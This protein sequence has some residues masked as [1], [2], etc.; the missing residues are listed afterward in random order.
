MRMNRRASP[1]VSPFFLFFSSPFPRDCRSRPTAFC[2][3]SF[4]FFFFFFLSLSL[5]GERPILRA[6]RALPP[7]FFSFFF[8]GGGQTDQD[9]RPSRF[10]VFFLFFSFLFSFLAANL[11]CGSSGVHSGSPLPF[12]FLF[13]GDQRS[14]SW[15]CIR[16]KPLSF[17]FFFFFRPRQRIGFI[18]PVSSLPLSPLFSFLPLSF[19]FPVIDEREGNGAG[20]MRSPVTH[21][22]PFFLF[23]DAVCGAREL[24]HHVGE[25]LLPPPLF[26]LF[27]LFAS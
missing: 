5:P 3:E 20:Q 27:P 15:P 13:L 8:T 9:Q 26:F 19:S 1:T 17:L 23:F 14:P 16:S 22:P 21:E 6:D 11:E 10:R 18:N 2:S 12:F 25:A 4:L 7:L 24:K